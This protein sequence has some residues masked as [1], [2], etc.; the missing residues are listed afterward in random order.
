[1]RWRT[2]A[3]WMTAIGLCVATPGCSDH[4]DPPTT[5]PAAHAYLTRALDLLQHNSIDAGTVDWPKI[6]AN[7]FE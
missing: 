5:R 1:M 3:A 2:A 7:A 4:A 6:R